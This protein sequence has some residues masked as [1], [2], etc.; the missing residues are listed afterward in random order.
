MPP[1]SPTAAQQPPR[2]F[3]SAVHVMRALAA[4]MVFSVHLGDSFNTYFFPN[5]DALNEAMP[6]VKRFGTFGVE[7]FFVI[8]GYVI[9][10]SVAKY[11]LRQFLLRRFVRIYPLFAA[12][13][14]VFFVLNA[15]SK[16]HP[17]SLSVRSLLL[18]LGFVD[19]YFGSPALSPNAWSLTFEANFYLMAGICCFLLRKRRMLLL[20]AMAVISLAFL[21]H[22]PIAAYFLVGCLAYVA[23]DLQPATV[24]RS[25]EFLVFAVWCV[26]AAMVDHEAKSP[27]NFALLV[28]TAVLFF[29]TTTP[30][31]TLTRLAAVKPLFLLGTI[32]YSFYLTHPYAYFPLRV[33]FQKLS[34]GTWSIGA[35]GAIYFP[36]ITIVAVGASYVVYRLLEAAPYRAAF[37]E[38]IFRKPRLE[39]RGA[40]R[41]PAAAVTP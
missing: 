39:P 5:S 2:R 38:S 40:D 33:I 30:T 32:S 18:N 19:I 12:F 35:A 14:I 41:L 34:L 11:D 13:T 36:T 20:V 21:A 4:L 24:P 37:G 27:A 9:M 7:L 15:F 29:V 3:N 26:L 17:E 22:F 10:T 31:G 28:A 16:L 23:R 8:S 25:V 6:Y 1:S